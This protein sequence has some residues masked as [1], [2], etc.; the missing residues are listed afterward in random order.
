PY[1]THRDLAAAIHD[2][3]S[4]LTRNRRRYD[5]SDSALTLPPFRIRA[6]F[7]LSSV[8]AIN[9]RPTKF[10]MDG[11]PK[12]PSFARRVP[13]LLQESAPIPVVLPIGSASLANNVVNITV[14][15]HQGQSERHR[16][17]DAQRTD[18]LH[19]DELHFEHSGAPVLWSCRDAS[20]TCYNNANVH[21]L[22][23]V[24]ITSDPEASEFVAQVKQPNPPPTEEEP[25]MTGKVR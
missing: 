9:G 5:L 3:S 12:D 14:E 7:S 6:A 16:V 2:P 24:G 18:E 25:D 1:I 4:A 21:A 22:H 13:L 8:L 15:Q 19:F 11:G 10:L 23:S 20:T 17:P